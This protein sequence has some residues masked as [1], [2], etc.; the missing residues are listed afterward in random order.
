MV[1]PG[2]GAIVHARAGDG[3]LFW[4]P[5]DDPSLRLDHRV[6]SL[7]VCDYLANTD[8]YERDLRICPEFNHVHFNGDDECARGSG[9]GVRIRQVTSMTVARPDAKKGRSTG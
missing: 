3:E 9:S 5:A 7:F 4:L 6:R 2:V 8:A 1:T